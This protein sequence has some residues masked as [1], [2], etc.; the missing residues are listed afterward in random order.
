MAT[1]AGGELERH[2]RGEH[3]HRQRPGPD[4]GD[5]RAGPSCWWSRRSTPRSSRDWMATATS[6]AAAPTTT[7][8]TARRRLPNRVT[9]AAP[10]TTSTMPTASQA[11]IQRLW[12]ASSCPALAMR[13]PSTSARPARPTKPARTVTTTLAARLAGASNAAGP[14]SLMRSS[15]PTLRRW[16][17]RADGTRVPSRP[18]RGRAGPGS[19]RG[20]RDRGGRDG[21]VRTWAPARSKGANHVQHLLTPCRLAAAALVALVPTAA[22]QRPTAAAT[23]RSP[24]SRAA[25]CCRS[26][27]TRPV[28][29]RARP[30]PSRPRPSSTASRSR[31]QRSPSRGSPGSSPAGR[32]GEYLA[33]ADNGFG[34]KANSR[35]LPDPRLHVTPDFKT[36]R[37]RHRR[38]RRSATSS[39][40]PTP[41]T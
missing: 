26:R 27:R 9:S 6:T 18:A 34:N 24:V 32:S 17:S 29:R 37:R 23:R 36:A 4:V 31:R 39:R 7:R 21:P 30:R 13:R 3:A 2:E 35:R 8:Q 33:M 11:T 10:A 19:P 25:P 15:V 5:R 20:A 16:M 12:P 22:A 1:P 14:F 41:T 38:R 28:R 40:S